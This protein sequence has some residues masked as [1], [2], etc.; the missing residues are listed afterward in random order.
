M[1]EEFN[2]K[3]EILKKNQSEM[4]DINFIVSKIK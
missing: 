3:K 2:K 4:L 1:R